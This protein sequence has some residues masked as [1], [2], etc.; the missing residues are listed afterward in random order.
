MDNNVTIVISRKIKPGCE[1]QYDDWLR[2]YLMLEKNIPGYVGTTIIT[3]GGTDSAI[4]HIIHKFSDKASF[5]AWEKSDESLKQIE[6]ADKYSTR[7]YEKATG[8]ETWFTLPDLK[9]IVAPPQWKMAIATFIGAYSISSLVTL[10]FTFSLYIRQSPYL[11]NT[12]MT[13]ILVA[14]LTYFAMP[15]LSRLLNVGYILLNI[16]SNEPLHIV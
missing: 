13:T 10:F 12:I 2:R 11:A 9:S 4:R 8:L 6:E 14:G 15:I 7:Y 5:D 3:Q 16:C 1:R